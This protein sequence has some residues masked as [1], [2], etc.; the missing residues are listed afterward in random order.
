MED[1]ISSIK[2]DLNHVIKNISTTNLVKI[3]KYACDKY[4]NEDALLTDEE[5]DKLYDLLKNKSPKNKFFNQI[6][7]DVSSK[8]KVKLPYHMGSM[9]KFKPTTDD[10]DKWLKK[11]KGP[12]VITD[13]LDG[14]S[15]LFVNSNNNKKLYTRGNGTY[16]T[17]ISILI[18][19]IKTLNQEFS[20]DIIIRGEFIISKKF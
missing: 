15:G 3:L 16:G 10:L 1:L 19:F 6:G 8:K 12:F 13:K 7:C 4:Y 17:D 2:S 20:S 5:Y 18:P 11:Y 14:V 9:D